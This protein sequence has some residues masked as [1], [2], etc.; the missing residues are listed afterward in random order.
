MRWELDTNFPFTPPLHLYRHKH[1]LAQKRYLSHVDTEHD[2]VGDTLYHV[3]G[4]CRI[5]LY[6]VSSLCEYITEVNLL[7]VVSLNLCL[8]TNVISF[9][10]VFF[11]LTGKTDSVWLYVLF[12]SSLIQN[13][14]H[15]IN[16]C[17]VFIQNIFFYILYQL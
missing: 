7:C 2:R 10:T 3:P 8:V 12:V 14:A 9:V 4:K 1:Y 13:F 6:K 5:V 11:F 17:N 16:K 15:F